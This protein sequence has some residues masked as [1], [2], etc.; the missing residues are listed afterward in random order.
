MKRVLLIAVLAL[1]VCGVA[2][3]DEFNAGSV[4]LYSGTPCASG[5]CQLSINSGPEAHTVATGSSRS[6]LGWFYVWPD[7][8]Y[9]YISFNANAWIGSRGFGYYLT[10]QGRIWCNGYYHFTQTKSFYEQG[11]SSSVYFGTLTMLAPC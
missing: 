7:M 4:R 6:Y 1:A 5:Q 3:A 10:V 9:H 11:T 2:K 8:S